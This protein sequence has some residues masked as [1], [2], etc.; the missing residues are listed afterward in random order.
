M[1]P[2]PMQSVLDFLVALD[3]AKIFYRLSRP[4]A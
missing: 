4:R 1:S 2:N 3:G